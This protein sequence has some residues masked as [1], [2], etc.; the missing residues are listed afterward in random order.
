MVDIAQNQNDS[1]IAS[2]V[3]GG[4][5]AFERL[6]NL[7]SNQNYVQVEIEFVALDLWS[8]QQNQQQMYMQGNIHEPSSAYIVK[9]VQQSNG[10]WISY[11][12]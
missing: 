9:R 1:A 10:S 5:I 7:L 11:T 3:R 8:N 12:N 6:E 4:A 2:Y